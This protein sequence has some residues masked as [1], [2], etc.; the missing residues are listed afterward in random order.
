MD[1]LHSY[2]E[3]P[4]LAEVHRLDPATIDA[5]AA[6]LSAARLR[7]IP[8]D[9]RA[10][11]AKEQQQSDGA[12]APLQSNSNTA[13]I[14]PDQ[15]S[16]HTM[17][18]SPRIAAYSTLMPAPGVMPVGFYVTDHRSS[19]LA[20]VLRTG[21]IAAISHRSNCVSVACRYICQLQ[22]GEPRAQ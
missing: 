1:A 7:Y 21:E 9:Y 15:P 16:P 5:I 22:H 17:P 20:G 8:G 13:P 3:Y 12:A 19:L 14:K 10:A 11:I 2:S 4:S 18:S 6:Q